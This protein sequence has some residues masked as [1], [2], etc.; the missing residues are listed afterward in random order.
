MGFYTTLEAVYGFAASEELLEAISDSPE[1]DFDFLYTT[2]EEAG[3]E[4]CP[5]GDGRWDEHSYIIAATQ[6]HLGYWEDVIP[7]DK[8]FQEIADES[9]KHGPAGFLE[10]DRKLVEFQEKFG[11][12]EPQRGK[13]FL[14]MYGG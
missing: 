12:E 6:V 13:W 11:V 9:T 8:A 7:L 4:A 2:T 1:N 5:L 3:L 14:T 10:F